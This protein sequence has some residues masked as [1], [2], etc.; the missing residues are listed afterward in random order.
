MDFNIRY[1]SGCYNGGCG[2]YCGTKYESECRN[3]NLTRDV[4]NLITSV[5]STFTFT[6]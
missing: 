2:A 4:E 1:H 3:F 6:K 5:V